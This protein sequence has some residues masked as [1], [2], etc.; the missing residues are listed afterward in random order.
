MLQWLYMYVASVY[1]QCFICFSDVCCKCA[2]LD[3]AYVSHICCKSMFEIFQPFQ[4]YVAISIFML[5]V[6]TVLSRCCICF[7]HML[8]VYV[9]NVSFASDVCCIQVFHVASVSCFRGMFIESCGHAPDAGRRGAA[10]QGPVNGP[11]GRARPHPGS[12]V[13]PT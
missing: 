5:Q 4:S 3:A 7:T 8:Q 13:P 9:L 1:L 10:S 12:Q 6:A 11:T 2:Y